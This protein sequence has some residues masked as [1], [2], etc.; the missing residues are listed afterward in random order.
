MKID[1]LASGSKGNA[2][3][4]HM[5]DV[6]LLLEA[7]I[8]FKALQKASGYQLSSVDACLITHEHKD[9]AYSAKDIIKSGIDTYMSKGTKEALSLSDSHRLH[10][11]K[12]H[13]KFQIGSVIVYPFEAAHDAKEPLSY[14]IIDAQANE[15][16]LFFTDTSQVKYRFS[17]VT[18]MLAECNYSKEQMLSSFDEQSINASL[19]SRVVG[20]HLSLESLVKY[21]E[22][23][24]L[25]ALKEI[26]L[27]HLS[28]KNSDEQY[29]KTEVQKVTGA[30]VV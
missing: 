5:T 21:L 7:G 24:D 25:K 23:S 22:G 30:L 17:G 4:V 26:Y 15:R 18:H 6:T 29:M 10:T 11:V 3:L 13:E 27:V 1:V 20:S 16:L 12:A 9:H 28:D 8:P 2:Y 14:L 19:V